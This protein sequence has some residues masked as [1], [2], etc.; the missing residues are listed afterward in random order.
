M[1]P[2]YL[3]FQGPGKVC[4]GLDSD[5]KTKGDTAVA[6]AQWLQDGGS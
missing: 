1:T 6:T 2:K 5:E 4:G 3:P